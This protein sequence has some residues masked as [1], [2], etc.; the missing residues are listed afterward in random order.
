MRNTISKNLTTYASILTILLV[1]CAQL[2]GPNSAARKTVASLADTRAEVVKGRNELSDVLVTLQAI[3]KPDA[4]LQAEFAKLK[5]QV[6]SAEAQ[7]MT[8]YDRAE[9]MRARADE[10]SKKWQAE[11]TEISDPELKATA[12]DRAN[13]V[14]DRFGTIATLSND[15]RE[16]YDPFISNIKDIEKYLT[17]D[18]TPVGVRAAKASFDKVQTAGDALNKKL[19]LLIEELNIVSARMSSTGKVPG[20]R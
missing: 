13:R 18:L 7:R 14:R 2:K 8:V 19:D 20:S 17:A 12:Q 9:D 5:A 10:Y 4:N 16:A 3:Q 11:I 6:K 1:G 15:A